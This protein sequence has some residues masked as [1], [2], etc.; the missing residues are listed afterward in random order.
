MEILQNIFILQG[1][2]AMYPLLFISLLGFVLFVER[3]LFLH[4]GYIGREEFLSGIKNLL[5]KGRLIEALALCEET[6]GPLVRIVKSALLHYGESSKEI[7]FAI[8]SAAILEL[9]ILEQRVGTIA[10]IARIAPMVGFLGTLVAVLQALHGLEAANANSHLF[11]QL[12]VQAL[13]SSACGLGIAIMATLAHHFLYGRIRTLSHDFEWVGH[14]IYELLT[15]D[16]VTDKGTAS[17]KKSVL[18]DQ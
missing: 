9:P 3:L 8:Q 14:K 1:G 15:T 6:P 7:R 5:A 16:A 10:A 11:N 4:K 18:S 12:L 17:L 2:L 13:I